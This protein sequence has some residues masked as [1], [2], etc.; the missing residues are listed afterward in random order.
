MRIAYLALVETDVANACLVH[1]REVAEQLAALGHAV[2]MI[3]PRPLRP[4]TWGQ[5]RHVWVRW[6]GFDRRRQ[7]VFSLESAWRLWR[8]HREA[9]F[10]LLYAREMP[11]HPFLARLARWLRVPLFVE[12][13]GWLLDD[14]RLTGASAREL[15]AI[16]RSQRALYRSATGILAST[17][18]TAERIRTSYGIPASHVAVQELGTNVEHFAPGDKPAARQQLGLPAGVPILL[19]AGSFHPHHDLDTVLEAFAGLAAADPRPVLVLVGQGPPWERLRA[20]SRSFGLAS[21]VI[22]PGQVPYEDVARYFQ[23]ADIG[24]L[25]LARENIR[26]RNGCITLK[27]WDYMA[28]GLPVVATDLPDTASYA[29]LKERVLVV[30]PEDPPAMERAWRTLLAEAPLRAR[31]GR[32]G[33]DYVRR[34]RSWRQAAE[35]TMRFIE[36]RLAEE[37][38]VGRR[39][40]GRSCA[41]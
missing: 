26:Q 9:P 39:G 30:P 18:G 20:R 2:T 13:N 19:F 38:V 27:L 34:Y 8:L 17:V 21:R 23:A 31:L 36:Q 32:E 14:L 3:L 5:V 16:E 29:L 7:Q 33:R 4:Q 41:E 15:R 24:L 1:T 28:A 11:Y 12:V 35:E 37:S 40:P 6:W 10:D 25:P 22:M